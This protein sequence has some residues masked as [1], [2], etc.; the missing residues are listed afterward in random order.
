MDP[1]T[2]AVLK[3]LDETEWFSYVGVKGDITE[4]RILSSWQEA[5]D[6]CSSTYWES[7]CLEAA[8]QYCESIVRVS[9]ERFRLWNEVVLDVKKTVVPF[10]SR[11]LGPLL[12][13]ND[14]PSAFEA[15]VRWDMIHICMETEYADIVAPGFYACQCH[16]Y[17]EGH[18]PC[19]WEGRFPAGRLIIY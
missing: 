5:V 9:K 11:K 18:F 6:H 4:P 14:L 17:T 7:I 10:V 2:V 3:Q 12:R 15:T 8:N 1:R 19:G 16:W 13:V